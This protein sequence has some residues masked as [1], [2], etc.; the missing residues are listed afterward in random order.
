LHSSGPNE[1]AKELVEVTLRELGKL[2]N[3]IPKDEL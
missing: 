3:P 2:R 1:N